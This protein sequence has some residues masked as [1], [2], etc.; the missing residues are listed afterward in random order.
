MVRGGGSTGSGSGGIVLSGGRLV[1][2]GS[3]VTAAVESEHPTDSD[4][5]GLGIHGEDNNHD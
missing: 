4:H 3:D 5:V 1:E 2:F